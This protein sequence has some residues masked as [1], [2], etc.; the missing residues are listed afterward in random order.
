MGQWWAVQDSTMGWDR[1]GPGEAVTYTWIESAR[2][3][4]RLNALPYRSLATERLSSDPQLA[5]TRL[6]RDARTSGSTPRCRGPAPVA[7]ACLGLPGRRRVPLP[8]PASCSRTVC[9]LP[10]QLTCSSEVPVTEVG[11]VS[12]EVPT[13]VSEPPRKRGTVSGDTYQGKPP[14]QLLEHSESS[15]V[16]VLKAPSSQSSRR[17][18]PCASLMSSSAVSES[19]EEG[20]CV[21]RALLPLPPPLPCCLLPPSQ[22]VHLTT[23]RIPGPHLLPS[24]APDLPWG[25]LIE[26]PLPCQHLGSISGP[27]AT[28]PCL[29]GP[30]NCSPVPTHL[31][32]HQHLILSLPPLPT[33]K[34]LC[35]TQI[36]MVLGSEALKSGF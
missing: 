28:R 22:Q 17:W 18:V 20:V 7:C 21:G 23:S 35:S 9:P 16:G 13:S 10:H 14:C 32:A 24:F 26:V 11:G 27:L 12:R 15:P 29:R 34:S 8:L 30:Q 5:P 3:L 2:P 19:G 33:L 1:A 36:N 31:M 25:L 6:A 4:Y